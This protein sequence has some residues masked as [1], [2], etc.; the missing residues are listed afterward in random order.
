MVDK[1]WVYV[2]DDASLSEGGMSPVYPKGINILLARVNGEVYA[3][4]GKCAHMGCPLFCGSIE[5]TILTCPCHDWR[6]DI[7]TGKFLDAAELRL[8]VYPVRVEDGRMFVKIT[9]ATEAS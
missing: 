1:N 9:A 4:D 8:K 2:L 5:G 7:K 6:F 3:L